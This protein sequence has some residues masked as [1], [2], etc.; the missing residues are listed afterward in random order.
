MGNGINIYAFFSMISLLAKQE[1]EEYNIL[2]EKAR[3]FILSQ[4]DFSTYYLERCP[5][6]FC[7]NMEFKNGILK[8]M[9][10]IK[11]TA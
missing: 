7:D 2:L 6:V 4:L 8:K 11:A 5:K 1:Y 10:V 9:T 3:L